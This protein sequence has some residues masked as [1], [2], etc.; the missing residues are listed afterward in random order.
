M[1]TSINGSILT[2]A[3]TDGSLPYTTLIKNTPGA[4]AANNFLSILNPVGSNKTMIFSQFL[5]FPYASGATSVL[6]NMEVWRISAASSGTQVSAGSISK[7]DTLQ[8]NT[9]ADV[10]TGNPTVTLVGTIPVLAIPPAV[11]TGLGVGSSST[12]LAPDGDLFVCHPGEGL[13]ARTPA[14]SVS[15]IWSLG[16][17]WVE[18]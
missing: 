16:F 8:P 11:T 14:G 13:V 1:P 5:C 10:R 12:V 4:V 15:Q 18:S 17:T 6:D 3:F 9:V 2:R 7:F